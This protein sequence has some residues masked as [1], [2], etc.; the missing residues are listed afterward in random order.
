[1]AQSI[2]QGIFTTVDREAPPTPGGFSRSLADVALDRTKLLFAAQ[3]GL[4]WFVVFAVLTW[5]ATV[6]FDDDPGAAFGT[7]FFLGGLWGNAVAGI[8]LGGIGRLV[9]LD[10]DGSPS[11][12]TTPAWDFVRQRWPGLTLGVWAV[13]TAF[14]LVA[15]C[16]IAIVMAL[17]SARSVGPVFGGLLVVPVFLGLLLA[18]VFSLAIW[19]LPCVM[20][21]EGS[22][23]SDAVR[24]LLRMAREAPVA[25]SGM[26]MAAVAHVKSMI[27]VA[28]WS[29]LVTLGGLL[30]S[31]VICGGSLGAWMGSSGAAAEWGI[32][33]RT[34]SSACIL[35]A[36][37]AFLMAYF[38]GGITAAYYRMRR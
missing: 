37:V 20:S 19:M 33:F 16:A 4:L 23:L 36:W 22:G 17:S 8:L 26:A 34:L 38:A 6:A 12:S 24:M 27:G 5:L 25:M 29:G 3:T 14:G 9:T 13:S 35:F 30:A 10:L 11:R 2:H 21:V 32:W 1:M 7:L 15:G 18:V 28:F 31:N